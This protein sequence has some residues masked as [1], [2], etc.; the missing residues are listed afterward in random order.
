MINITESGTII[1]LQSLIQRFCH[2][3]RRDRADDLSSNRSTKNKKNNT[4]AKKG[5]YIYRDL[6]DIDEGEWALIS[7]RSNIGPVNYPVVT[8]AETNM[9]RTTAITKGKC[10]R[11]LPKGQPEVSI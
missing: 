1:I 10:S 9:L 11:I 7:Y 5:V 3:C 2:D 4:G 8:T 6:V